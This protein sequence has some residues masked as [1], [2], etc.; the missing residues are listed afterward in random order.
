MRC[1]TP[2][3]RDFP[4]RPRD[5]SFH[6]PGGHHVKLTAFLAALL[7]ATAAQAQQASTT[8]STS[9]GWTFALHGFVSMSTGYQDGSFSFSEGQQSLLSTT[10]AGLQDKGSWTADVRQSRFNFS[11]KGPQVLGGATP[12]AVLEID[13]FNG[14]GAGNYGDVSLLNRMRLAYSELNWGAGKLQLGQQNDLVFA[15]APTSLS[16]I[17]FP[18]GYYTGN[19]GWRR[20]GGFGYYTLAVAPAAKIEFAGEV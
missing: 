2:L 8:A 14:F 7:L 16:H 6:H 12:T 19:I 1:G 5:S 11:V 9:S 10:G 15:M 3:S 13:F 20:P 18:L 4:S 17:A